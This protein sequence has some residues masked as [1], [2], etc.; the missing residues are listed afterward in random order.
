R[1]A[2]T[3]VIGRLVGILEL[4]RAANEFMLF[5]Y[6]DKNKTNEKVHKRFF[7]K[8]VCNHEYNHVSEAADFLAVNGAPAQK[9]GVGTGWFF[10]Q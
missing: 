5:C 4:K 6:C 2:R 3:G 7:G 1:D 10:S 8:V 9:A